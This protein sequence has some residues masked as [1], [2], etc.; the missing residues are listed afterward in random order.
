[1]SQ[2]R[3][4]NPVFYQRYVDDILAIFS[5]QRHIAY[6]KLRLENSSVLKF[7]HES[8]ENN[9]FHF[10]DVKL[11]IDESDHFD[12]SVY[13]KPTDKG[14]YTNYLSYIPDSYKKSIIKTLEFLAIKYS[15]TW[16]S[17]NSEI[18]RIRQ[19]LVNNGFPLYIIDK[20]IQQSLDK[21]ISPSV[22]PPDDCITFYV[23][24]AR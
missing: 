21:Y 22:K 15:S 4:S 23:R 17:V 6:L 2:A 12:T 24:L 3:V 5:N 9:V 20:I 14:L 13:I 16:H 7:T 8:M 19:I 10:L 18:E 11:V 1:M